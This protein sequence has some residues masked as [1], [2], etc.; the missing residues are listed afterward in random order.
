MSQLNIEETV[1]PTANPNIKR[2]LEPNMDSDASSD[3]DSDTSHSSSIIAAF[4]LAQVEKRGQQFRGPAIAYEIPQALYD[5]AQK[6]QDQLTNDERVLLLSRGDVFGKALAHPESLTLAERYKVLLWP[7]PNEVHA[8]IRRVTDGAMNL[9]SE[10]Y[11]KARDSKKRGQFGDWSDEELRLITGQFREG[12]P[13]DMSMWHGQTPGDGQATNLIA[14]REGIDTDTFGAVWQA[15]RARKQA[16]EKQTQRRITTG[17]ERTNGGIPPCPT[18]LRRFPSQ[19]LAP[20]QDL[21]AIIDR[22]EELQQQYERGVVAEEEFRK[23]NRSHI[24]ALKSYSQNRDH[25]V[26]PYSG[27]TSPDFRR[28][29]QSPRSMNVATPFIPAVAAPGSSLAGLSG[30]SISLGSGPAPPTYTLSNGSA[31]WAPMR[32]GSMKGPAAFFIDALKAQMQVDNLSTVFGDWPVE[33]NRRWKAL[34][35]E[36]RAVYKAK[37][38]KHRLESWRIYENRDPTSSR[39]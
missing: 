21:N 32:G 18:A 28:S 8:R 20:E 13:S 9:P 25:R 37:S 17:P 27:H 33:V 4:I 7:S 12:T 35:E 5:K 1:K 36:E 15:E 39:P 30:P 14:A 22:M 11:A 31:V 29:G 26:H 24:A 16:A 19:Y 10:L 3:I 6:Q 23:Q 38:E 34:T 2:D